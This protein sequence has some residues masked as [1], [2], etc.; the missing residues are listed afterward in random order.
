MLT[1]KQL[2]LRIQS[3]ERPAIWHLY[4]LVVVDYPLTGIGFGMENYTAELYQDYCKRLP[5]GT[6]YIGHSNYYTHNIFLD[7][8][9][10]T[11]IPGVLLFA[12][13]MLF[14]F[15]SLLGSAQ[16][17]HGA[18]DRKMALTIM[19]CLLSIIVQGLMT[20]IFLIRH[21]YILYFLIGLTAALELLRCQEQN[22]L[23]G[24]L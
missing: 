10:R 1:P 24:E 7:L 5:E 16:D 17:A 2:S 23:I 9:V 20:D 21:Y 8:A 22:S 11:G 15:R 18:T 13:G 19:A 12:G 3:M 14:M 6:R 4:S